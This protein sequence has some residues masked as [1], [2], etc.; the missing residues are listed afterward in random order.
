MAYDPSLG[1][2][3]DNIWDPKHPNNPDRPGHDPHWA[4][5]LFEGGLRGYLGTLVGGSI[6]IGSLV[7]AVAFLSGGDFVKP[8]R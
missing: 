2:D 4:A 3:P 8:A 5:P 6:G 7:G 1:Y